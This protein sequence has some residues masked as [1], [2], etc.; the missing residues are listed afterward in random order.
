MWGIDQRL[1][2]SLVGHESGG[3]YL[4]TSARDTVM[5]VA[6][7][8]C[9]LGDCTDTVQIAIPLPSIEGIVRGL[10]AARLAAGTEK[11]GSERRSAWRSAYNSIPI[12][13]SVEWD[14][15][16]LSLRQVLDLSPGTIVRLPR[17]IVRDTRVRLTGATKYVGEVGVEDG[18][19]A[20][21][22]DQKLSPEDV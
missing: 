21:R 19:L 11:K 12:R 8:E 10:G 13:L 1:T 6:A 7:F 3:R 14:A 5:F 4:Q 22:I 20:I 16:D 9:A 18:R 15:C 2:V 17:D